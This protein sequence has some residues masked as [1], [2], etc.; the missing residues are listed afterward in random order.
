MAYTDEQ[1][2]AYKQQIMIALGEGLSIA[3]AIAITGLTQRT[4][5]L[6]R[7][8]DAVFDEGIKL[9]LMKRPDKSPSRQP[10]AR[11]AKDVPPEEQADVI[12]EVCKAIRAGLPLDFCCLLTNIDRGALRL[13]MTEDEDVA[14][15][16]NKAQAQ[17]LLWWV[18][19]IRQGAEKDWKAALAYL[20]RIFP[21]L[22]SEVKAVDISVRQEDKQQQAFIDVTPEATIK[23]LTE[24]TDEDLQKIIGNNV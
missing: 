9:S 11:K 18:S 1:I 8:S 2:T 13:W 14:A 5:Y 16:V 4:V 20:E 24:M 15:R 12:E 17:N 19:K 21:H 22:F 6:W 3:K 10:V 23:R 7:H